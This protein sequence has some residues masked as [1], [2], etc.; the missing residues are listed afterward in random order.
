MQAI[1]NM[2]N[3][4]DRTHRQAHGP[5]QRW[6]IGRITRIA[7]AG[8]I[9]LFLSAVT[10]VGQWAGTAPE[11][12]GLSSQ[13]LARIKPALQ[14]FV[15]HQQVS[16]VVTMIARKGQVVYSDALGMQDIEEKKPM[17]GDTMC[18]IY[19]MTKPITSAAVMMLYEEDKL[20]LDDPVSK[21]L[22][23]LAGL[24]VFVR[25]NGAA[26]ELEDAEREMTIRDLLRHTSG[27]TYGVFG[28]TPVDLRYLSAGILA[29][30]GTLAEMV[31]KLQSLPLLYQPG[32]RF[33]YGVSTDVLGRI[34][35][36]ASGKPFDAFLQERVFAPLAMVDTGFY[37]PAEKHDRLAT[38]Y[39]PKPG[40]GLQTIDAFR[41]SA[42][43]HKPKLLSGGG[44]L[45]ST[46][47]DYMRFC[48]MLLNRGELDGKRLL[49]AETVDTM[50]KNQLPAQAYPI[51]IGGFKRQG[52]GF[53]LG[54]SVIAERIDAAPYVPVGEY[55]WGGAAS[56]HFWISPQHE[57]AV[58][59]L[60]QYMPFSLRLE[61]AVKPLVY[62]AI[63][64]TK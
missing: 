44:G 26:L 21:Y 6:P 2:A 31:T 30:D 18:R 41:S 62:D 58:I 43:R 59:V 52:V 61:A 23:E 5:G 19:S 38:N 3:V 17:R 1:T 49:S 12:V 51:E 11:Q 14:E 48:L 25:V 47:P 37:V 50:T 15:D 45:V 27:L 36:V 33:N 10:V 64:D 9:W 28:V 7:A 40:G 57:L 20:E 24:K 34:V 16:G 54:F 32:S 13:R 63:I 29:P 53:G 60:T 8:L 56:T 4:S 46:A 39:G 22:P 55:G 35:E 42:F